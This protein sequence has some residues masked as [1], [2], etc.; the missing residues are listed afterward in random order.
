MYF[1]VS[2]KNITNSVKKFTLSG[3]LIEIL[4][5]LEIQEAAL[6]ALNVFMLH[7]FE[8]LYKQRSVKFS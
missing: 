5:F 3:G 4:R 8:L 2:F 1:V 7:L 6:R